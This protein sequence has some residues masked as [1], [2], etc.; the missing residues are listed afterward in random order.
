MRRTAMEMEIVAVVE[1]EMERGGGPKPW[2]DEMEMLSEKGSGSKP[3][4]SRPSHSRPR[5][6]R[7]GGL[8]Q[9]VDSNHDF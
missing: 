8:G 4:E 7:G 5:R 6:I 1:M 3:G 9:G 2:C